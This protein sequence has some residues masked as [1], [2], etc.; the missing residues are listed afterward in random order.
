MRGS[1]YKRKLFEYKKIKFFYFSLRDF[2]FRKLIRRGIPLYSRYRLHYLSFLEFRLLTLAVRLKVYKTHIQGRQ[3]L[4]HFGLNINDKTVYYPIYS[5]LPVFIID[6]SDFFKRG[7]SRWMS[8]RL[9]TE[10]LVNLHHNRIVGWHMGLFESFFASASLGLASELVLNSKLP[11]V[12]NSFKPGFGRSPGSLINYSMASFGVG[13]GRWGSA[14]LTYRS[15]ALRRQFN[16]RRT[17][18]RRALEM[19]RA[20]KFSLENKLY[21]NSTFVGRSRDYFK[22]LESVRAAFF[23]VP[24]PFM[25][26]SWPL[27]RVLLIRY[28]KSTELDFPFLLDPILA[29]SFI[30]NR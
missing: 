2:Q 13:M 11:S 7:P 3:L 30:S 19:R 29:L 27:K 14:R 12:L 6:L 8:L 21:L 20:L 1:L 28:P 5:L 22:H 9:A 15:G 10:P 17:F 18:G 23:L 26:I 25:L 4:Q 24:K 16:F